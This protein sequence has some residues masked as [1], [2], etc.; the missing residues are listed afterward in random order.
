MIHHR[1]FCAK[2]RFE[3]F[4]VWSREVDWLPLFRLMV[5]LWVILP[6]LSK[7]LK[8]A[9]T[10]VFLYSRA[11]S[12]G[13]PWYSIQVPFNVGS[14]PI[15]NKRRTVSPWLHQTENRYKNPIRLDEYLRKLFES[16]QPRAIQLHCRTCQ[17]Q[18]SHSVIVVYWVGVKITSG[19]NQDLEDVI[20]PNGRCPMKRSL[21]PSPF[22]TTQASTNLLF[23]KVMFH[24][25]CKATAT[26]KWFQTFNLGS[27][28]WLYNSKLRVTT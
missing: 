4:I 13:V 2:L 27:N 14:A 15:C 25:F 3:K 10:S 7:S 26:K 1:L 28:V 24:F 17:V 16:I 18:T 9:K 5:E 21:A 22:Q 11:K 6:S 20:T 12:N 19:L 23:P 8:T